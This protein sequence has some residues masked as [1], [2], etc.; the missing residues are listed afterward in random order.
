MNRE[1][2]IRPSLKYITEYCLSLKRP[3]FPTEPPNFVTNPAQTPRQ[4]Q[5]R[6]PLL[7]SKRRN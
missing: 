5:K 7:L 3:A 1:T 4:Y 2:Y 6:A